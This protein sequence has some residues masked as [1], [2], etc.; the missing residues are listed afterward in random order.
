MCAALVKWVY[1]HK[2]CPR[3][4]CFFTF[5]TTLGVLLTLADAFPQRSRN[6][7]LHIEGTGGT[8][9]MRSNSPQLDFL[10]CKQRWQKPRLKSVPVNYKLTLYIKS[11]NGALSADFAIK[12]ESHF[13]WNR[14]IVVSRQAT[15]ARQREERGAAPHNIYLP[16][17]KFI[18]CFR[19][20]GKYTPAV[21]SLRCFFRARIVIPIMFKRAVL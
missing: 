6:E 2:Q 21:R 13:I 16:T 19:L 12:I 3:S 11:R 20:F 14:L 15:S 9:R 8:S 18:T 7:R 10:Q 17:C 5:D 1:N 4:L